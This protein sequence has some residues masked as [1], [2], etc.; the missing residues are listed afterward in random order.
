MKIVL[1]IFM[2]IVAGC[3]LSTRQEKSSSAPADSSINVRVF[4]C[5]I[6]IPIEYQLNTHEDSGF[7]FSRLDNGVGSITIREYDTDIEFDNRDDIEIASKKT[8]GELEIIFLKVAPG[9]KKPTNDVVAIHDNHQ[10]ITIM[11]DDIGIW[12]DFVS[13]CSDSIND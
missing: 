3:A 4:D 5:D 6:K 2:V 13:Q 11:G 10:L 8:I 9:Y 12:R 7:R 1:I